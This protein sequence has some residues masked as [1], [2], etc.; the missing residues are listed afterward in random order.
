MGT[1]A[2]GVRETGDCASAAT[3]Q[4]TNLSNSHFP[5][6]S[7]RFLICRHGQ[8]MSTTVDRLKWYPEILPWMLRRDTIFP[9][10]KWRVVCYS[11]SSSRSSSVFL[12]WFSDSQFCQESQTV[13]ARAVSCVKTSSEFRKPE[14]FVVSS[15]HACMLRQRKWQPLSSVTACPADNLE[16]MAAS[17]SVHKTGI[18]PRD[19]WTNCFPTKQAWNS[20]YWGQRCAWGVDGELISTWKNYRVLVK[21]HL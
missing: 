10:Q 7:L 19:P 2:G 16:H 17:I 18:H 6:L 13:H 11:N 12:Q 3:H 4:G 20:V 15:E 5:S 1:G 9:S 14:A 8:G 21:L